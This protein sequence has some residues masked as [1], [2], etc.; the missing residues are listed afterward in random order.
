[1]QPAARAGSEHA[2]RRP[3]RRARAAP[4]GLVPGETLERGHPAPAANPSG[5]RSP[6]NFGVLAEFNASFPAPSRLSQPHRRR[7]AP[8]ARPGA[9]PASWGRAR[10]PP[11]RRPRCPRASPAVPLAAV[12]ALA[13]GTP[14]STLPGPAPPHLRAH[15]HDLRQLDDVG[16]HRVEDVLQ[17]VDDGDQR[18]HGAAEPRSGPKP[19]PR[20]RR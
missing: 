8:S 7:L 19:R 1:M 10:R 17:L 16:P 18:L 3:Q 11:E 14:A 6:I 2:A 15:H 20:P 12:A 9:A 13:A 4:A 5:T